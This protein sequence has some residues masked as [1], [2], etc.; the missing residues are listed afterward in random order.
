ARGGSGTSRHGR[1]RRDHQKPVWSGVDAA[2]RARGGGGS[3][4]GLGFGSG[5]GGRTGSSRAAG[6]TSSMGRLKSNVIRMAPGKRRAQSSALS[7]S[8]VRGVPTH[9]PP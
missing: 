9:S 5:G 8:V 2:G 3:G 7:P 6:S 4:S 1:R